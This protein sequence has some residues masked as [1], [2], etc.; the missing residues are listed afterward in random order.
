[1][2]SSSAICGSISE[3]PPVVRC[4]KVSRATATVWM[5]LG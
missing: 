5:L 2:P 3:R 4:W 1:L